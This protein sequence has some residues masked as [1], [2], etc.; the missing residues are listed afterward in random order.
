MKKMFVLLVVLGVAGIASASND[1]LTSAASS[2]WFNGANW[3]LGHVPAI[4]DATNTRTYQTHANTSYMPIINSGNAENYQLEIGGG[5][6]TLGE[7]SGTMT[8]NGG[9]MTI[10]DYF[11]IGASSTSCRWGEFYMNGGDWNV[12]GY[13]AVGYGNS[14]SEV[15][16]MMT[17]IGGTINVTGD[18]RFAN[19]ATASG[20]AYISGGTINVGGILNMRPGGTSG[21]PTTLLDITGSGKVVLAGDQVE[22]VQ[23]YIDNGWIQSNGE[24]F[25]YDNV[26]WDG[27]NTILAV[28]EPA[29]VC[30]LG[31]GALSLIRRKK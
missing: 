2:D 30:L 15:Q 4:A 24:E 20:I 21:T 7:V 11:R 16:G 25:S 23:G 10:A 31:L 1:W 27:T 8:M 6:H 17:M 26:V 13:M 19:G 5:S 9:T 28:P 14:G 18:L 3:S 29:T 22:R 12:G